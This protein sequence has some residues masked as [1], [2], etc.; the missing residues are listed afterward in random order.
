MICDQMESMRQNDT[1]RKTLSIAY[2][3]NLE[4]PT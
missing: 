4:K 1:P 2:H 3:S